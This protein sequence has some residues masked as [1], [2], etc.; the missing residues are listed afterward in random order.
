MT[1]EAR[2]RGPGAILRG[3]VLSSWRCLRAHHDERACGRASGAGDRSLVE[4]TCG[5]SART[6]VR[7]HKHLVFIALAS[8]SCRLTVGARDPHRAFTGPRASRS[9]RTLLAL[10]AGRSWWASRSRRTGLALFTWRPSRAGFSLWTLSAA[11]YA[12]GN[13][14]YNRDTLHLH[15]H[16]FAFYTPPSY[17]TSQSMRHESRTGI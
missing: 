1:A 17:F 7:H 6:T 14:K 11:R 8:A 15:A 2:W 4:D 13:R 9:R 12:N 10:R 16:T 5:A 3:G